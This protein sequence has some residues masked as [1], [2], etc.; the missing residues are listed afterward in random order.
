MNEYE[1]LLNPR[2]QD[3]GEIDQ[4]F[5]KLLGL[6][7]GIHEEIYSQHPIFCPILLRG[8]LASVTDK[9]L[10]ETDGSIASQDAWRSSLRRT[11]MDYGI[12]R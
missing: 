12:I 5:A 2:E 8:K 10:S 4:L 9:G 6:A 7:T 3:F 1:L 11:P